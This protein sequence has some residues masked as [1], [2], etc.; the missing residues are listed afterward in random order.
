MYVPNKEELKIPIDI[1]EK[2]C[3][4]MSLKPT[5]KYCDF[6]QYRT[7]IRMTKE[8]IDDDGNIKPPRKVGGEKFNESRLRALLTNPKY[9]GFNYFKDDYDQFPRLQDE[10][11]IVRWEYAH[12]REHG[13]IISPDLFARVNETLKRFERHKPRTSK[14]GH[15]YLL[16]GGVLRDH[17]GNHF[18][19]KSAKSSKNCY[20]HNKVKGTEFKKHVK[21]DEIESIVTNRIRQYLLESKTLENVLSEALRNRLVGLPLIEEDI[22][23][24]ERKISLKK[25]VIA[26]FSMTLENAALRKDGSLLSVCAGLMT[27]KEKAEKELADYHAKLQERLEQKDR[28]VKTFEKSTLEEYLE[29]TLAHFDAKNDVEKKA[30]VQAII[31]EIIIHADNS[32]ELRVNPDSNGIVQRRHS[33]GGKV[34]L[35]SK[36]RGGR[37]SNPRPPA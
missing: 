23:A 16:S 31:P 7:K 11:K 20:Y 37:D 22:P 28:V 9:R 17:L 1:M 18:H 25:E 15:A 30:I 5:T 14:F 36:W 35:S 34:V 6:K 29:R 21:K 32:V 33:G 12:H 26:E 8:S 19:G 27:Q 3:V 10:N 2:F 24:I 4:L 13:D